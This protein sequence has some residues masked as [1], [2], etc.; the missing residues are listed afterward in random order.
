MHTG[1]QTG[2]APEKH[3]GRVGVTV[4]REHGKKLHEQASAHGLTPG[5]YVERLI[6][7]Q[8]PTPCALCGQPAEVSRPLQRC[9]GS[10]GENLVH[11]DCLQ[12]ESN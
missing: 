3:S 2:P 9:D 8:D 1:P 6:D 5:R 7:A 11:A 4:D 10:Q 12:A